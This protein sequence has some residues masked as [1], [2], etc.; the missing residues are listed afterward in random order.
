RVAADSLDRARVDLAPVDA[1]LLLAPELVDDVGR[2]DRAEERTGRACLDLEAEHRLL[3]RRRDRLR[4]FDGLRLVARPLRV[5]LLE[6]GD[7]RRRRLLRELAGQ[8]EVARVAT[9]NGDDV[10]AK[11]DVVDVLQED[12]PRGH[13]RS[14]LSPRSPR[15]RR[16]PRPP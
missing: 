7:A 10:A 13:Y 14:P 6:L 2:S 1:D 8:E 3:E 9:R 4:V 16:P 12:D 11:T 5:A 15:S